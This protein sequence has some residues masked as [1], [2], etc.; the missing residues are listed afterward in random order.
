LLAM[1]DYCLG[2]Q[3]RLKYTGCPTFT[4]RSSPRNKTQLIVYWK[5]EGISS[6]KQL[7]L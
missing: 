7:I 2:Q 5:D 3:K 4:L 6:R 1:Y